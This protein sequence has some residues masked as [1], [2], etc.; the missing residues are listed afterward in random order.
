[1]EFWVNEAG[2]LVVY[3]A[4]APTG[5]GR[6][7][8]AVSG[9]SFADYPTLQITYSC[10]KS[11][12]LAVYKNGDDE[13]ILSKTHITDNNG[14]IT[15]DIG[16]KSSTDLTELWILVDRKEYHD[17]STYTDEDPTK[18]VY[19]EF[20]FLDKNG[21]PATGES[22]GGDNTG[23][24]TGGNTGNNG[25]SASPSGDVVIG[26]WLDDA[27]GNMQYGV[28]SEGQT[29]I[30][31]EGEPT[32]KSRIYAAVTGHSLEEYPYLEIKYSCVKV[33]NL[34]VYINGTSVSL[35][36][37]ETIKDKE[38]TILIDLRTT[39]LDVS[40]IYLMVDRNGRH[41][42][43]TYSSNDPTKTV[44]LQFTFLSELPQ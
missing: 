8:A 6:I 24:N 25:G 7:Y 35:V 43:N 2:Q 22:T 19:L 29:V 14:V 11:F 28:N 10:S 26:S 32:S 37:Y 5:K 16:K 33:F 20:A 42:P 9:H 38:G 4:A 18:T 23:G 15:I 30:T 39:E 27:A 12:N 31:F 34:A 3:Y 41:D 17:S 36:S 44:Y 40:E 1:M 21:N 13:S